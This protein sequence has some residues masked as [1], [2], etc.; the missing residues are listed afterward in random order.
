VDGQNGVYT[1]RE[2]GRKLVDFCLNYS[3]PNW[4]DFSK[5]VIVTGWLVRTQ[6]SRAA[7]ETRPRPPSCNN[8]GWPYTLAAGQPQPQQSSS[9]SRSTKKRENK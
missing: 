7:G 1:Y 9:R 5:W 4:F 3:N 6:G 2:K 8:S